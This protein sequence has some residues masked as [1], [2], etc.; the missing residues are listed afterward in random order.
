MDGA[1]LISN[2]NSYQIINT[3]KCR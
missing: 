2:R 3:W 1:I